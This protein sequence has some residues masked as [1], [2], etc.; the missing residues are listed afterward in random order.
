M[1]VP[2]YEAKLDAP[3]QGQGRFSTAQ[4]SPS[5]MIAPSR[6]AAEQAQKL[7]GTGDKIAEFG[8]KKLEAGA[9]Q[10]AFEAVSNYGVEL[11][12]AEGNFLQSNVSTAEQEYKKESQRLYKKYASKLKNSYARSSF[13][14]NAIKL[15]SQST[16]NFVRK[17]N[18]RVI[19][20][21]ETNISNDLNSNLKIATNSNNKM[22]SRMEAL[23]ENFFILQEAKNTLGPEKHKTLTDTMYMSLAND[24]LS[25]FVNIKPENAEEIVDNFRENKI[26][27]DILQA[28]RNNLSE[29][30]VSKIA[31]NIEKIIRSNR[32]RNND[33]EQRQQD[34][35]KAEDKSLLREYVFGDK[36]KS[37]KEAIFNQLK[38]SPFISI[39]E[40]NTAQKFVMSGG[41]QGSFNN[42]QDVF[43]LSQAIINEEITNTDQLLK[44]IA[45]DKLN[46][47]YQTLRTVLNPL[48]EET[49]DKNFRNALAWGL[50]TIGFTESVVAGVVPNLSLKIDKATKFK[51]E[52][53]EWQFNQ[54][55]EKTRDKVYLSAMTKAKA[56]ID[57]LSN[58]V[59]PNAE[60]TIF[61][62][63]TRYQENIKDGDSKK[64]ANSKNALLN[65]LIDL[66]RI[67]ASQA[68]DPKFD[69]LEFLKGNN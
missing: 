40:L 38:M 23:A 29:T 53:L 52:M 37:E 32:E 66:G 61:G 4:L 44:R 7:A 12:T 10:E 56:V 19:A 59:D 46:V 24:T 21:A 28:A 25:F 17:N 60:G 58:M 2:T 15:Q 30:E 41:S 63:A 11:A 3:R 20:Q 54:K 51:A 36:P 69:V 64:I 22:Q 45:D 42:T 48:I 14:S 26:T 27:D 62:L 13:A 57:N 35:E 65:Y 67:N 18:A 5:A 43:V 1:K 9:K 39:S 47:N 6:A 33:I 49:K 50:S 55:K 8:F 34:Q 16:I 31:T 68:L